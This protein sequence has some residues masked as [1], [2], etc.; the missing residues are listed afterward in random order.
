MRR[1]A[2]RVGFADMPEHLRHV[3]AD[4]PPKLTQQRDGWLAEN[5]LTLVD[6]M[7]WRRSQDPLAK[8]RPPSRRKLMRPEELAELDARREQEG[9][10]EW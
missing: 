10:P 5:G 7:A 2:S 6:F 3:D 8:R 1:K 4:S 9:E